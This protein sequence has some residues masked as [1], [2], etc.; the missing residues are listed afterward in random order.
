M[1]H[2]QCLETQKHGAQV[3]RASRISMSHI[4]NVGRLERPPASLGKGCPT[5]MFHAFRGEL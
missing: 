2:I 4:L 1:R 5:E 3:A